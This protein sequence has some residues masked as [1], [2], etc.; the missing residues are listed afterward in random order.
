MNA[1]QDDW[2]LNKDSIIDGSLPKH[3]THQT[4]KFDFE[5]IGN[6]VLSGENSNRNYWHL[7]DDDDQRRRESTPRR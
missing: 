4:H 7:P 1:H 3:G 5:N 2:R 6:H